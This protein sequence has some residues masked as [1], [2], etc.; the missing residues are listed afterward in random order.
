MELQA[1][2]CSFHPSSTARP[3][4][5][6]RSCDPQAVT[7]S[8]HRDLDVVTQPLLTSFFPPSNSGSRKQPQQKQRKKKKWRLQKV[9]RGRAG[10]AGEGPG[11][12]SVLG[13]PFWSSSAASDASSR[14]KPRQDR[15]WW[16]NSGCW[17]GAVLLSQGIFVQ[18]P[19]PRS[20]EVLLWPCRCVERAKESVLLDLLRGVFH[21]HSAGSFKERKLL[22]LP[23]LFR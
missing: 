18:S 14:Y 6:A 17:R 21:P 13:H 5:A 15:F 23:Q 16:S 2:P 3:Q 22:V 19:V 10:P 11:L 9:S 7:S 1:T 20:L 12:L 4:L 8:E